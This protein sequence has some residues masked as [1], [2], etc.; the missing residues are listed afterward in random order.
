M[1]QRPW[2]SCPSIG[3]RSAGRL[4]AT[5]DTA[6]AIRDSDVSLLCVGTPSL[7][8]GHIDLT[9]V[10]RVCEQIGHGHAKAFQSTRGPPL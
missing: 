6:E 10:R 3:W 2:A 4:R 9:Y 7:G 1:E 8:N 5:T